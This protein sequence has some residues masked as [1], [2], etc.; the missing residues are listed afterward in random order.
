MLSYQ[1]PERMLIRVVRETFMY[2]NRQFCLNHVLGIAP[3]VS[4]VSVLV[5]PSCVTVSSVSVLVCACKASSVCVCVCVCVCQ[6]WK[7]TAKQPEQRRQCRGSTRTRR[8][9]EACE[10]GV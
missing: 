7:R 2:K 10:R 8:V 4:S 5:S 9:N 6:E 1:D 3:T